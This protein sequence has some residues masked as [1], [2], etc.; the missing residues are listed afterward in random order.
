M[1]NRIRFFFRTLLIEVPEPRSGKLAVFVT[2]V[3]MLSLFLLIISWTGLI[4]FLNGDKAP[5]EVSSYSGILI[6]V[7]TG[8]SGQSI[9]VSGPEGVKTIRLI[10]PHS[11]GINPNFGVYQS[12]T[13]SKVDIL[14]EDRIM[15]FFDKQAWLRQLNTNEE[16]IFDY[17][18][19]EGR[20]KRE[21]IVDRLRLVSFILLL[22]MLITVHLTVTRSRIDNRNTSDT[23]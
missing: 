7:N 11:D 21:E 22:I 10:A 12:L 14:Y 13:G 6:S 18:S 3:R 15:A 4:D 23:L 16:R 2:L 1:I 20:K 19:I 17:W 9:S 5:G 8:R